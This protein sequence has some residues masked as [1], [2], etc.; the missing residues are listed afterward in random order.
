MNKAGQMLGAYSMSHQPEAHAAVAWVANTLA[1]MARAEGGLL[2]PGG[3]LVGSRRRPASPREKR[4][5]HPLPLA[6]GPR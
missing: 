3:R 6:T 2:R 4:P 5:R 1:D